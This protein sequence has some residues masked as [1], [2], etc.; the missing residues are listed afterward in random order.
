MQVE[1][2]ENSKQKKEENRP[3]KRINP[4]DDILSG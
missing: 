4:V 1:D 2:E 3:G